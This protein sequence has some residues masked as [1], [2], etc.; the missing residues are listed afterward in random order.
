MTKITKPGIYDL[1]KDVYHGDQV[2]NAPDLVVGFNRGYENA[3]KS[4]LGSVPR[5]LLV[6]NLDP[7]SGSH[8]MDPRHVPG[9]LIANTKFRIEDPKLTDLTVSVLKEF[10][11]TVEGLTGRPIW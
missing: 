8:L 11:I 1:P 5:E 10:G 3:D 6:D 2:E 9:V 4:A 7:W